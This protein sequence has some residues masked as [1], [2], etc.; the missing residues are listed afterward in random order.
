MVTDNRRRFTFDRWNGKCVLCF[1]N[2]KSFSHL[3]PQDLINKRANILKLPFGPLFGA[4]WALSSLAAGVC[5][6]VCAFV[7]LCMDNS[8]SAVSRCST[9][10]YIRTLSSSL[11][12]FH[13]NQLQIIFNIYCYRSLNILTFV[14]GRWWVVWESARSF[15]RATG[16]RE[17]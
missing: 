14:A 9:H 2:K 1:H 3:L 8:K 17:V 7:R 5:V 4:H 16:C 11:W 13:S 10:K 15:A 6:Y 12:V